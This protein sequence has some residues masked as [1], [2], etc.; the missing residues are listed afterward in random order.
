MNLDHLPQHISTSSGHI[1]EASV[2]D[3]YSGY[4]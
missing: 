4:L 2:S 3:L 1:S